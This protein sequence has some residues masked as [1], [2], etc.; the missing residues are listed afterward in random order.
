MPERTITRI[1][2]PGLLLIEDFI[3]VEEEIDLLKLTD[4]GAHTLHLKNRS[5]RHYGYEFQYGHNTIDRNPLPE[6]IPN[7][8]LFI[9]KKL[10]K[11]GLSKPNQLTINHYLPGQG[12]PLHV[13]THSSFEDGII[14][15]S[16][17]SDIL[18]EFQRPDNKLQ[19]SINLP[20]R[21]CLIMCGDSRFVFQRFTLRRPF[22]MSTFLDI[23][24]VMA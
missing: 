1:W 9:F 24:G 23:Y 20:R 5:V 7:E 8:M 2:P 16:M 10:E 4:F 3:T 12:I 21:S 15:L 11:S 13:D 22:L 17:G 19:T 6:G 14:S 18:M